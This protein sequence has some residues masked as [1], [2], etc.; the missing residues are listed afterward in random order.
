MTDFDAFF[1]AYGK[2]IESE[3]ADPKLLSAYKNVVPDQLIEFWERFGFG[4]YARGLVWIVNPTQLEDVLAEWL[5]A[6]GGKKR[7]V[8]VARTAF[9]NVIYWRDP[10]FTFLD[11]NYNK[12]FG[13]GG[14][15]ELLFIFYLIDKKSRKSVLEE[16]EFKKAFKALGMLK[17]DEMYAYTLPLAM[18]GEPGIKNMTKVKMREHLSILAGIHQEA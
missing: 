6:K 14:N 17:R 15:V 12:Q 8:P 3:R 10:G 1:E 2:P 16:P 7:A 18:G 11:V 4:G 9:G 5:P 13:A